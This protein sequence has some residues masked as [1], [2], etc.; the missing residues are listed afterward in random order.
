MKT[1]IIALA[2]GAATLAGAAPAAASPASFLDRLE[3]NPV[4]T[5]YGPEEIFL[6]TGYQICTA[7]YYGYS[8]DAIVAR[9]REISSL[10]ETGANELYWLAL[11]E[12]C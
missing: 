5:F 6:R 9:T 7:D 11:E 10:T 4:T 3:D 2:L 8:K 12:L 1:L